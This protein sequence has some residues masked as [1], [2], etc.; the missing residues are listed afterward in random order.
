MGLFNKLFGNQEQDENIYSPINGDIIPLTTVKDKVFST[1]AM[2]DGV[3]IIPQDGIVYS[4]FDGEVAAIF[5]TNH[6]IGLVNGKGVEILI[7]I[8]IDTVELNGEGFQ[9]FVK[10]GDKVKAHDKLITFDLDKI[11]KDYD[12]TVMVIITNDNG[13]N[14]QIPEAKKIN[15]DDIIFMV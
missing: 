6:A 2:G 14:L 10:Q 15:R 3:G 9:S 4:P 11:S 8:G 7:H 13:I 1:K 5:P 12:T